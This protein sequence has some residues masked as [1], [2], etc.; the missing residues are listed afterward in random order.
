MNDLVERLRGWIFQPYPIDKLA[1][2][3]ADEIERLRKRVEG[4]VLENNTLRGLLGNSA[5]PC[6][7][8]GLAAED[9]GKC[10][11]GF[12]GCASADDQ[13][14]S[15]HFADGYRADQ[16]EAALREC[17]AHADRLCM[18]VLHPQRDSN[19]VVARY[20][21]WRKDHE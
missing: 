15:K 20:H 10:E 9:Q 17:V 21:E 8:C 13:M 16:A 18:E 12:P 1:H 4:L 2:E 6:P 5:L 3:A 11:H 19:V 14:L 7:Y